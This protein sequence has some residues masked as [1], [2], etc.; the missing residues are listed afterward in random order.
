MQNTD[1]D[2]PVFFAVR[3]GGAGD[4]PDDNRFAAF[5]FTE[6]MTHMDLRYIYKNIPLSMDANMPAV[7]RKGR[8]QTA[9][10]GKTVLAMSAAAAAAHSI[11]GPFQFEFWHTGEE[12]YYKIYE[13]WIPILDCREKEKILAG[14]THIFKGVA[15][16]TA[17][18]GPAAPRTTSIETRNTIPVFIIETLLQDLEKKGETC[19]ISLKTFSE[20]E[21]ILIT[22]CYHFFDEES[23]WHWLTSKGECP[24]CKKP[25]AFVERY[26]GKAAAS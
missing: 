14:A 19:S 10:T 2:V 16:A 20:C 3:S 22:P 17:V 24:L 18:T 15:S 5:I 13:T 12:I 23:L 21:T 7:Y 1:R 8:S 11:L 26:K 4:A 6:K 9:R 25:V